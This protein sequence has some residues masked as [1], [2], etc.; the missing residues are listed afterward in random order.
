MEEYTR[1]ASGS[2]L[3]EDSCYFFRIDE[4][5][6][7]WQKC[8]NRVYL[9]SERTVCD[10]RFFFSSSV[11]FSPVKD[12]GEQARNADPTNHCCQRDVFKVF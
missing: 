4:K 2:Y 9:Q 12:V 11:V 6:L 10:K 3:R 8:Q 5:T 7:F 1:D